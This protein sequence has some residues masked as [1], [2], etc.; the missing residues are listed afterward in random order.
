M[1]KRVI[2]AI[3]IFLTLPLT[4]CNKYKDL[5]S[6]NI[7]DVGQGDCILISTPENK[8]ILIDGGDENSE[9][10]IKSYLKKRKIKKL[11]IVIAT[12]F[13]KD[14][15]GSL[16]YII[17]KF[18]IGK[19]Y[20]S[21][22]IDKSQ[23]YNNLI[24]SCRNKNLNFE[25]LKKGDKIRITKDINIIVLNPSYIQEN[26]NLNSIAINLSYINMD[27]LF[28]GDC[29]ESNEVD[30]INS[31]DL[32]NVDFLKIAHHGSSSS[33]SDK[34]IKETSPDIAV[35]SCGY[36]NQYGHPHKSTLDTLNKYK[37]KTFRTDINGDLVF[38]SDGYK[39]FTTKKYK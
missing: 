29:E 24:K 12:H 14:H 9:R 37:V 8:N 10:V 11:D 6:I 16:D 4:S 35:I 19:V 39:I 36:K 22:D 21:K 28:T 30:M 25:I 27:F 3:I 7:I 33:S 32:E 23:A 34:F 26:K 20:T 5:L 18:N 13:D 1:R 17:D 2:I 31:Y 38:Y 15:I